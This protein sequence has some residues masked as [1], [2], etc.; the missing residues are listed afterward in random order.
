M[1]VGYLVLVS[2]YIEA[3]IHG[4]FLIIVNAVKLSIQV[5]KNFLILKTGKPLNCLTSLIY[6][7][8]ALLDQVINSK[9][10]DGFINFP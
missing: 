3:K 5:P 4:F 10:P 2:N 9:L 7:L 1:Y 8:F 6:I